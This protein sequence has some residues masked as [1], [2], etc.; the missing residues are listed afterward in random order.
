MLEVLPTLPENS[1]DACVTDP[2]YGLSD[3]RPKDVLECLRAWVNGEVYKTK[4]KGFMASS[5]DAWVPGPEAWREVFRVLKP[6]G[7]CLV[8]S[9]PKT[10]DLMTIAIR[11]AGFEVRT[12]T[13]WMFGMGMPKTGLLKNKA[14]VEWCDCQTQEDSS[15]VGGACAGCG[16]LSREFEGFS[17]ELKPAVEP[18][19]V[20]R[21]PLSEPT[22]AANVLRWGTGALNIDGCRVG[23]GKGETGV[24]EKPAYRPNYRNAVFGEGMGGGNAP[25]LEAG[26]WPA[27]LAHD[28]SD[29][30][31]DAFAAFPT[32]S[33]GK[34]RPEPGGGTYDGSTGIG[35][36]KGGS[37]M[38]VGLKGFR[39]G[40]VDGSTPAR[41]FQ[42][43]PPDGPPLPSD[44]KD[45]LRFRYSSKAGKADRAGSL[46]PC[47]KPQSLLR[48]LARLCC[49]PGG[50]ILD[51]FAGSGSMGQAASAKGFGCILIEREA[52]YL[53][54]IER[55]LGGS[56]T[57]K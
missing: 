20:A 52:E 49:P 12:F 3:H 50:V 18:I 5:W 19:L 7:F 56:S 24:A 11:L 35:F 29:E 23:L 25:I 38:G 46:H 34:A 1:I 45:G 53:A 31:L 22:V 55:R 47:V 33:A 40:D 30:V 6:G 14:G 13:Y 43:C 57:R 9:A 48:W 27:N 26:R 15:R 54:D 51:P 42:G 41:F 37:G 21:K 17:P 8:F 28:G 39:Y 4:R 44:P 16:Q 2:P 10:S 36:A 32:H